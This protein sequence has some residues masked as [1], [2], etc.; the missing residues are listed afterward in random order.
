MKNK[1]EKTAPVKKEKVKRVRY[2]AREINLIKALRYAK[3]TEQKERKKGKP[4]AFMYA[5]GA[6]AII[7]A[8]VWYTLTYLEKS[9]LELENADLE[10]EISDLEDDYDNAQQLY[11]KL[12]YV[13]SL[14]SSDESKV[15]EAGIGN[16]Q[17]EYFDN[18]LFT[19]IKKHIPSDAS[20]VSI[21]FDNT[22]MSLSLTASKNTQPAE[23]V[24]DLRDEGLFSEVEYS[25]FES[26]GEGGET[27]FS[28]SCVLAQTTD[29]E[30][31]E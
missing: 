18:A 3:E 9:D 25:G 22:T 21:S 29:A 11:Y 10:W 1:E 16:K 17:L 15:T 13:K 4:S 26:E 24:S 23:I 6:L 20:I 2:K 14:K 30:E 7:G 5:L 31:A 12:N 27:T 19:R 28:I 8:G